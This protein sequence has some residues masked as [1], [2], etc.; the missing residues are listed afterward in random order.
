MKEGVTGTVERNLLGEVNSG[1]GLFGVQQAVS[2][3][4]GEL[5]ILSGSALVC[6]GKIDAEHRLHGPPFGGTLVNIR[7]N[8]NFS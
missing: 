2:A 3:L 7:F 8:T 6:S 4:G 1:Y 5:A